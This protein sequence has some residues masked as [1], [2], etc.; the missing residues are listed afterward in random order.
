MLPTEW[1]DN[2]R[3]VHQAP[4]QPHLHSNSK[5]AMCV[6]SRAVEVFKRSHVAAVLWDERSTRVNTAIAECVE[7]FELLA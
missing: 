2:N 3:E 7:H 1:H 5:K 4:L 6:L